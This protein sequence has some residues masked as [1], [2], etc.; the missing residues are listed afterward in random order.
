VT[1]PEDYLAILE[2]IQRY[3]HA[4][5]RRDWT[6]VQSCLAPEATADYGAGPIAGADAI[7]AEIVR[8]ESR[9]QST[10]HVLGAPLVTSMDGDIAQASTYAIAT[11]VLDPARTDGRVRVGS[12]YDDQLIR[13]SHGWQ[14]NQRRT[15]IFWSEGDLLP[16]PHDSGR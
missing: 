16:T 8:V 1:N 3:A 9:F 11:H 12:R 14:F 6:T 7:M 5:D 2:V 15:T 10:Q 13:G 4:V